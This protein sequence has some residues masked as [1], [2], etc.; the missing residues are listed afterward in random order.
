MENYKNYFVYA[1]AVRTNSNISVYV[2]SIT[3]EN[4]DDHIDGIYAILKDGIET[5]Y[6]HNFNLLN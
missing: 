2:P 5:N 1:E 4:I 3:A 6:V